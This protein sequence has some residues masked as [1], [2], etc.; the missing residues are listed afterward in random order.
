LPFTLRV[1]N[2]QTKNED[3][4]KIWLIIIHSAIYKSKKGKEKKQSITSELI[5]MKGEEII[6]ER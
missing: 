2:K 6:R 3:P 4:H 5:M 1:H